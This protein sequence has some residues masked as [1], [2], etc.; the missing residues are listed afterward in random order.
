MSEK[1]ET[2][3][4]G[5]IYDYLFDMIL[6]LQIKPG[7]RIPEA[8]IASEFGVSRT[9]I[10]EALKQLANDGIINIYPK[11]YAEVAEYDETKVKNIGLT[12]IALDRL[13]V[14]LAIY[15]GSNAEFRELKKYAD[16]C[17]EAAKANNI[18]ARIRQDG[19]F[20]LELCKI[21]KNDTLIQIERGIVLQLMFLQACRYVKAEDMHQQYKDHCAIIDALMSRD[22]KQAIA[23][24]TEQDVNFHSLNDLPDNL[25]L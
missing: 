24:L 13:A 1:V 23:L 11:R 7:D 10:R 18:S 2:G 20:H 9:P 14:K 3:M 4:S 5:A 15:Y 22:E 6:S 17:Y 8:K 21:S 25:Y 19:E 16:G 12:R